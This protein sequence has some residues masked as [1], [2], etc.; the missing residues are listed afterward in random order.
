[1]CGMSKDDS[2]S[3]CAP[4]P[5]TFSPVNGTPPSADISCPAKKPKLDV[6][7]EA[8]K[9]DAAVAAVEAVEVLEAVEAVEAVEVVEAVE[10]VEVAEPGAEPT[11]VA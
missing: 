7:A 2:C 11:D 10:A 3:N 1:M 9:A 5:R 8:P 6:P 4:P